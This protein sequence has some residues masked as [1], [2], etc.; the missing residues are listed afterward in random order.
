MTAPRGQSSSRLARV[1]R[2]AVVVEVV[3]AELKSSVVV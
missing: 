2:I 3:E 1:S